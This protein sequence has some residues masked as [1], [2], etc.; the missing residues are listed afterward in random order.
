MFEELNERRKQ[1]AENM[2]KAFEVDIEKASKWNIGDTNVFKGRLC[3]VV[4]F[5]DKGRPVWKIVDKKKKEG[6]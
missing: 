4:R 1:I 2:A 3:Q 6:V 5:N